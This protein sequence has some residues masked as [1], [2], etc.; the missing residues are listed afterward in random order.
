MKTFNLFLLN[1]LFLSSLICQNDSLSLQLD[2]FILNEMTSNNIPGLSACIV[3]G[4]QI[5]WKK[6]YGKVNLS[7]NENVTLQTQFTLASISKLFSATAVVQLWQDNLLDIDAD[8]NNY[9]PI[10]IENPNF[11]GTTITT[12]Q[13]LTHKS[14]LKDSETD[15]QLWDAL[16]DPIY[17]L[18][19]F[20]AEYFVNGGSLYDASNF[21]NTAPGSSSY[22]YSNAGYTLLGYI[23]QEV[24]GEPFNTYCAN[25]IFNKLNMPTAGWFYAETDSNNL[26]MPYNSAFQAYGYYSVPE[27]P[28]AMLKS[29]IIELSNFLI[30]YTQKGIFN[31]VELVNDITFAS[32]VPNTMNNGFAWW[33]SDT[34]YGD[35]T[36]NYWSH[37]GFMNGVRTQ[38]NYYPTDSTGLIILTN[39]EGS[40]TNIQNKMESFI[41]LFEKETEEEEEEPQQNSVI[42]LELK[43]KIYPNPIKGKKIVSIENSKQD[44]VYKIEI[45][46][47]NTKK[48]EDI[49]MLKNKSQLNLSKYSAG[50]YFLK[51]FTTEKTIYKKIVVQ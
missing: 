28:A 30:A 6:A 21:S 22:W 19:T 16:G 24:S 27:Y 36:G 49:T 51:F 47:L 34:W 15:L 35:A 31:Q 14:S 9:L 3:K 40:Y 29:N 32:L 37:G 50:L 8:I 48:V 46:N 18:E 13:L 20:C 2:T 25:N 45:L 43:F 39:G 23:V 10:N 11:P 17:D 1:F 38:L 5:V 7:T 41:P 42:N 44:D 26:A 12:R 4:D 33:G